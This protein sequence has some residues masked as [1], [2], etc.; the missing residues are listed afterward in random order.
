MK[1][2]DGGQRAGSGSEAAPTRPR[3]WQLTH[4]EV[5]EPLRRMRRDDFMTPAIAEDI[6]KQQARE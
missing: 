3:R 2:P 5:T 6:R 1:R 4:R